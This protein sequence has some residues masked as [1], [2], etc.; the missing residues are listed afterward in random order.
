MGMKLSKE[1][2]FIK[3]IKGS[4]RERGIRVKK[5]DLAKFFCYVDSKCPWLIVSGPDIHPF[6]WNKV[7]KDINDLIKQGE[8]IPDAFFAFYGIIRDIL[9]DAEKGGDNAC[10]LALMENFLANS[11]PPSS[12]TKSNCLKSC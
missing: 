8:E 1:A 12:K 9:K 3:E 11:Q 2:A 6:T 4:L 5:K 10:L 7:G